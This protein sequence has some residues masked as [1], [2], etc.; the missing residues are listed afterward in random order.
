MKLEGDQVFHHPAMVYPQSFSHDNV[1]EVV[2]L[3]SGDDVAQG[4]N[5]EL[6][7][8][9]AIGMDESW[10]ESGSTCSDHGEDCAV[11]NQT[12]HGQCI[13]ASENAV[14]ISDKDLRDRDTVKV[15]VC[16]KDNTCFEVKDICID[17]CLPS[18]LHTS[19][20][21]ANGK[22]TS[23]AEADL[24]NKINSPSSQAS[25]L[26]GV[27]TREDLLTPSGHEDLTKGDVG[28]DVACNDISAESASHSDHGIDVKGSHKEDLILSPE[29]PTCKEI[30]SYAST[31]PQGSSIIFAPAD[32]NDIEKST[33]NNQDYITTLADLLG[34][35]GVTNLST[36]TMESR[37][38]AVTEDA[39]S[40]SSSTK[41]RNLIDPINQDKPPA[42]SV[43]RRQP[44][45][46]VDRH[47]HGES[48]FSYAGP[49]SGSVTYSGPIAFS[50]SLSVRSDSSTTSTRSFAF[51]ILHNEWNSSPVRMA[52]GDRRHLRKHRG[53]RYGIL[54][55][56]F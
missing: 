4:K 5:K 49:V 45:S 15:I 26:L 28:E 25:E 33:M 29:S 7:E 20:G 10:S 40:I 11:R 35:S 17:E 18:N 24:V 54:C 44:E 31:E 47:G 48:S 16:C 22:I 46:L 2:E 38:I 41:D 12:D 30:N 3:K 52:K 8:T 42:N 51:P 9:N 53:W 27:K 19:E 21:K 55:C 36:A 37:N 50:G 23:S 39:T 1:M 56:R 43:S 14:E 34:G 32:C 13:P 6:Y